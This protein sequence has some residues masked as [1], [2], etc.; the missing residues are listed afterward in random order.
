MSLRLVVGLG[1]PGERYRQTRHNFGFEVVDRMAGRCKWEWQSCRYAD[2]LVAGNPAE[3]LLVKPQGYMNL[4]GPEIRRVLDWFKWEAGSLL[5]VVDDVNLPLGK[6]RLRPDGSS[7]GHNGLASIEESL[8]TRA[9]ARLRGGVGAP[10]GSGESL[11][12]HVLG[13]FAGA[14]VEAV[15]GMIGRAVETVEI[16][17]SRGMEAAMNFGNGVL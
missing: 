2:A 6:L 5:V 1:N 9:Y 17:R 12:G 15:D 16:C 4:S 3:L 14:E 13:R 8:G 11:P 7:G 10:P